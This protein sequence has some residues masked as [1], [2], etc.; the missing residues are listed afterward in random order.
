[1]EYLR[2]LLRRLFC[3]GSSGDLAERQLFFQAREKAANGRKGGAT[4]GLR[5]CT[6]C[7]I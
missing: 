3:E 6:G 4:Q 7:V 1:M 2:S 5:G